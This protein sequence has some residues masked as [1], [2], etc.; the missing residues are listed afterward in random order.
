FLALI[1]N[2]L[3]AGKEAKGIGWGKNKVGQLFYKSRL[4]SVRQNLTGAIDTTIKDK[5]EHV[6]RLIQKETGRASSDGVLTGGPVKVKAW[7]GSILSG[8]GDPMFDS[9]KNSYA[10]EIA[11]KDQ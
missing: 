4:S 5:Q 11:P 8:S 7:L 9:L 3:L 2:Y 6:R 1:C 10:D